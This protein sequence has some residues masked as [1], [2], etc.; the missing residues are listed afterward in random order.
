MKWKTSNKTVV[1]YLLNVFLSFFF[2]IGV[3]AFLLSGLYLTTLHQEYQNQEYEQYDHY[4]AQNTLELTYFLERA[5]AF[6]ALLERSQY[7]RPIQTTDYSHSVYEYSQLL[8]FM[9]GFS[10]TLNSSMELAMYVKQSD[11]VLST[12]YSINSLET[13]SDRHLI[14][15]FLMGDEICIY[16]QQGTQLVLVQ[17][18]S[19][20]SSN[21]GIVLLFYLDMSHFFSSE[22]EYDLYLL[23]QKGEII[24]G[25]KDNTAVGEGILASIQSDTPLPLSDSQSDALLWYG[26]DGQRG[27]I[28]ARLYHSFWFDDL[29]QRSLLVT[30]GVMFFSIFFVCSI[31]FLLAKYHA[32]PV[33][34]LSDQI[35]SLHN[36]TGGNSSIFQEITFSLEELQES[37]ESYANNLQQSQKTIR[38]Q[39]VRDLLWSH[40]PAGYDMVDFLQENGVSFQGKT[41]VPFLVR[42][43]STLFQPTTSQISEVNIL[44]REI[45]EEYFLEKNVLI[46]S[47]LVE[48]NKIVVLLHG[49]ELEEIGLSLDDTVTEIAQMLLSKLHIQMKVITGYPSPDAQSLSENF[50]ELRRALYRM[51]RDVKNDKKVEHIEEKE[52]SNSPYLRNHLLRAISSGEESFVRDILGEIFDKA[53]QE[54][55]PQHGRNQLFAT[56]GSAMAQLYENPMHLGEE[57]MDIVSLFTLP[58]GELE[59]KVEEKILGITAYFSHAQEETEENRYIAKAK[60]YILCHLEQDLAL[61]DIAQVCGIN[62]SYFSRIFKANT[63]QTP[64]QFITMLRIERAKELLQE[65][66]TTIS[67][68]AERIG[69]NDIR[70]FTRYFKKLEGCTPSEYRDTV[71]GSSK[72]T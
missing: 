67:E 23:D 31:A 47:C 52:V 70:S 54:Q 9:H 21:D 19:T 49:D 62:V 15:D 63:Q 59:E 53:K 17:Q 57:Q 29:V 7:I 22:E 61:S 12:F 3:P 16:R 41:I 71:K 18:L 1:K 46:A 72:K 26:I 50:I 25:D 37:N 34:K 33:K 45:L 13:F 40:I 44:V 64:L 6:L 2:A 5:Q 30:F 69:Y 4:V 38:E 68:I 10:D 24:L 51:D 35:R 60:E 32:A 43:G 42:T 56:L 11:K 36:K 55:N 14:Y 48:V 20:Y 28:L 39:A 65:D 27:L 66:S 58:E 8:E